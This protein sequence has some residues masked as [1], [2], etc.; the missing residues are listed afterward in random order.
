[1]EEEIYEY[2][3][4]GIE[5]SYDVRRCIHARECV[6]GLP[7]VFDPDRRPWIEPDK[8]DVDD[9]AEVIERC[10]TGALHYERTDDGPEEAVPDENTVTVTA[11]GP[12]YVHGDSVI[13]T[14]DG[15]ELLADT[16][17]ALCRCGASGN[18]PLCD[19]SHLEIEF[20]APG[21]V[22]DDA[23]DDAGTEA[24]TGEGRLSVVP[25][26]NGPLRVSGPFEMRGE[27]DGSMFRGTDVW[28]CRCGHSEEKP[29][30][31]GTHARIGFSTEG[32]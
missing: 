21:T 4:E 23:T 18:K 16:R 20:E 25:T 11:D 9:L 3:G 13:E 22:A 15:E 12:H 19:N 6:R 1:M 30:C 32:E 2:T 31:D 29:F 26:S 17:V 8:A 28:L 5:V 7:S 27:D 24:R 10:P 14:P